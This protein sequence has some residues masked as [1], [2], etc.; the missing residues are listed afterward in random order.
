LAGPVRDAAG[1]MVYAYRLPGDMSPAWVASAM[2][3]ASEEQALGTILDPRFDPKRVAIVDSS[4]KDVQ[5]QTLQGLPEPSAA[6]ATV[7]ATTDQSYDISIAPPATA[8]SALVVSENYYPGWQATVDGKSVP[9]ARTNFNLIGVPLPAGA[10]TVQLRFED[11]AYQK[12]KLLTLVALALAL[13]AWIVGGIVETRRRPR[14]VTP[15]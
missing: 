10:R 3:K 2:V 6:R 8:G 14:A 5:A 1:S 7:T 13:V 15:A 12:G 11:A 9:V 4:A